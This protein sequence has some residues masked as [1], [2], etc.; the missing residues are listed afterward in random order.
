MTLNKL[1][2]ELNSQKDSQNALENK[3]NTLKTDMIKADEEEQRV[4][5]I[6]REISED[7]QVLSDLNP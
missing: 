3:L 4:E 5:N 6:Q 2:I 7:S 1:K